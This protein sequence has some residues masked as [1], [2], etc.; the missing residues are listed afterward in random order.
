MEAALAVANVGVDTVSNAN[1]AM[2][3]RTTLVGVAE[4]AL[5]GAIAKAKAGEFV[6]PIKGAGAV[7]FVQVLEAT[8]G[9]ATFNEVQEM[10]NG[11]QRAFSNIVMQSFY[12]TN[13]TL[14]NALTEEAEVVDNRYKF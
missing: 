8:P 3:T 2:N 10:Q 14:V 6:G 4:P 1:F 12:G 7:Y 13:E 9:D 5:T 11:A